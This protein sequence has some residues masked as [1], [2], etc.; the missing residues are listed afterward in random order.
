GEAF[1]AVKKHFNLKQGENPSA[2]QLDEMAKATGGQ[3]A[4]AH[5]NEN[6]DIEITT[7]VETPPAK[8]D[9]IITDQPTIVDRKRVVD[10][11][12]EAIA[13]EGTIIDARSVADRSGEAIAD[14]GAGASDLPAEL[15]D[16]DDG[17]DGFMPANGRAVAPASGADIHDLPTGKHAP[18]DMP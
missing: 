4:T 11:S 15:R 10:A 5:L 14:E 1:H 2:A 17:F 3:D 13:D 18:V 9:E 7:K 6:G 12:R 16:A 8:P